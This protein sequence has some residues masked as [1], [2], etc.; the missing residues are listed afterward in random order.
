MN[1]LVGCEFSGTVRDAFIRRGHDAVSCDIIPSESPGPHIQDDILSHLEGWDMIIA[2]PPCTYL[3]RS[4]ASWHYQTPEMYEAIEFVNAIWNAP[5]PKLCIEN[6]V[7]ALST[8][9]FPPSQYIQP[10]EYGHGETK[11]TCLWHRSLPYLEP[12]N[13]VP[14]RV[15]RIHHLGS[16]R[17]RERS[18]TYQGVADAMAEQWG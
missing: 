2:F 1:I 5:C 17:K 12:T 11:K 14:G 7:G 18:L 8:H 6:P 13:I 16:T 3:A 10:W 15:A 9:W 4:G